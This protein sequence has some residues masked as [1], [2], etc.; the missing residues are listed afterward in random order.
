[1]AVEEF[2]AQIER[3]AVW[4]KSE[5]S[6]RSERS[7]QR[8]A[9][10]KKIALS[11]EEKKS[12]AIEEK[13]R[14][15]KVK[16]LTKMLVGLAEIGDLEALKRTVAAGGN[17]TLAWDR[18]MT[19]IMAAA[20]N[21]HEAVALWILEQNPK[22]NHMGS[23]YRNAASYC[24]KNDSLTILKAVALKAPE[25]FKATRSHDYRSD[26]KEGIIAL[27]L[28]GYHAPKCSRWLIE[29]ATNLELNLSE[30]KIDDALPLNSAIA[31]KDWD[32]ALWH[33]NRLVPQW[34]LRLN[35]P[36]KVQLEN[37]RGNRAPYL[38]LFNTLFSRDDAD[39]LLF[40]LQ[41]AT[42]FME[43]TGSYLRRDVGLAYSNRL[44]PHSYNSVLSAQDIEFEKRIN[45]GGMEIPTAFLA[46]MANAPECLELLLSLDVYKN[47]VSQCQM[48]EK[49]WIWEE[50]CFCACHPETFSLLKNAGFDFEKTAHNG[51]NYLH[52]QLSTLTPT[53]KLIEKLGKEM[54]GLSD[55]KDD[56]GQTPFEQARA[57]R[58]YASA[59]INKW[60]ALF[61]KSALRDCSARGSRKKAVREAV[62]NARR[63]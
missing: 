29:N 31:S 50:G 5:D 54:S 44:L 7:A 33:L 2:N 14:K 41:N 53:Q 35:T 58:S 22:F 4:L 36:S 15:D 28:R 56:S 1:M 30:G 17:I 52:M 42:P 60:E 59:K 57:E 49:K 47:P 61:Q 21:G 48:N 9:D 12:L 8:L 25:L 37:G 45:Q 39:G 34:T 32:T 11:A 46:A 55:L 40:L 18:Q 51:K 6:K 24:L 38:N 26:K 63:L 3:A 19:P 10:G 20:G 62:K 16:A 43:R 23:I 13:E 27:A